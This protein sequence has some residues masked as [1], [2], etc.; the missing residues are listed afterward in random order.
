MAALAL[1]TFAPRSDMAWLWR[2]TRPAAERVEHRHPNVPLTHQ[3]FSWHF[4]HVCKILKI[5]PSNA[6][7][8]KVFHT[9]SAELGHTLVPIK[10]LS[11]LTEQ[12]AFCA[13]E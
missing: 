10:N 6:R 3:T 1:L 4:A 12:S 11:F 5:T 2:F 7:R 9:T 13:E 8:D